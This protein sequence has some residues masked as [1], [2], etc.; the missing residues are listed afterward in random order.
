MEAGTVLQISPAGEEGTESEQS[1]LWP[2]QPSA[3]QMVATHLK[4]LHI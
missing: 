3:P 4:Q 1:P 2:T